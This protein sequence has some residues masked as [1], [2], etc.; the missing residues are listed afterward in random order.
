MTTLNTK[1]Q[2]VGN[3]TLV[4]EFSQVIAGIGREVSEE[5]IRG[6]AIKELNELNK[7]MA[8][9][10]RTLPQHVQGM[11]E[12]GRLLT[13]AKDDVE[14]VW[15]G[16]LAQMKSQDTMIRNN[17]AAVIEKQNLISTT[18]Y[19]SYQKAMDGQTATII[20]NT[21]K[22]SL[23]VT[24]KTIAAL[25]QMATRQQED[26]DRL[27]R[28][29]ESMRKDSENQFNITKQALTNISAQ[30]DRLII[31]KFAAAEAQI[32]SKTNVLRYLS[33]AN[34]VLLLGVLAMITGVIKI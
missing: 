22:K 15:G 1:G 7:R 33:I 30:A 4:E 10:Q 19:N 21:N 27:M 16:I 14:S 28:E 20:E 2:Q 31:D 29:I 9:F 13:V 34:I 11:E 23:A 18:A 6:T 25:T 5:V 8:D 32:E 12:A 26:L 24:D 17:L 3:N